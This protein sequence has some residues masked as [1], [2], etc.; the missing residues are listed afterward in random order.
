MGS[1]HRVPRSYLALTALAL[2][3][4]TGA[5]AQLRRVG[6]EFQVNSF[7]PGIESYPAV[8][9]QPSGD[10]LVVW[11]SNFGVDVADVVAQRFSS[12]GLPVGIEIPVN[13]YLPSQQFG[14]SVGLIDDAGDFAV[15]WQSKYQDGGDYGVFGQ[16]FSSSGTA[17]A[18]E[19]QVNTYTS[20]HQRD[21]SVVALNGGDFVV[22]WGSSAYQDGSSYGIFGQRFSSAGAL[23]GGE[24]QI[25]AF[26][27]MDQRL[28]SAAATS[29]SGDFIVV[30]QSRSQ[31]G[32]P[33]YAIIGRRFSSAGAALAG[34]FQ[35]NVYTVGYQRNASVTADLD[36][37]FV[38]AW[39]SY[40]Q[41]GPG[42][43]VLA[44]R[45]SSA[46]DAVGGEIVVTA[47]GTNPAVASAADNGFA[48]SWQTPVGDGSNYG[49]FARHYSSSGSPLAA[50]FQVNSYTTNHQQQPSVAANADGVFVVAWRSFVQDD[51]SF[52]GVFGQRLAV[53]AELDVDGNGLV[54]ALTDGLLVVRFL[55]GFGGSALSSGA[56]GDACTRCDATAIALYLEGL[57]MILDIDENLDLDALTDGLLVLRFV[58][59]FTGPALVTDAVGLGCGRCDAATEIE[60]Y[61][62]GLTS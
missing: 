24:L 20:G 48:V 39:D 40:E 54:D 34:E 29:G 30:W 33:G 35:V 57:G 6:I 7:T 11:D 31:D 46:G 53:L 5:H 21:A 45:F 18:A 3:V 19:F 42:V 51:G 14:A 12:S 16:R 56:V 8:A 22:I 23:L 2:S 58:F 43:A 9:V 55:F 59:G 4:A 37:D 44:R 50:E 27:A 13:T 15:V 36:G 17:I 52:S 32:P 60:P 1:G 61:L 38:I 26:T 10:F 49:V 62:G 25:N 28:P 41:L 47:N